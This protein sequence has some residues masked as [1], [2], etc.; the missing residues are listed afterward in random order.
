MLQQWKDREES[1]LIVPVLKITL[2]RFAL[3]AAFARLEI[4]AEG[5]TPAS[6]KPMTTKTTAKAMRSK[7]NKIGTILSVT[8]FGWKR[9]EWRVGAMAILSF[10]CAGASPK[11]SPVSKARLIE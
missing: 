9:L 4:Y 7:T 6:D 2:R 3:R 10:R 1:S 11:Q 8:A 5:I